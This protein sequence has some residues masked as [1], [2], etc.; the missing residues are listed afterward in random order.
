MVFAGMLMALISVIAAAGPPDDFQQAAKL[1]A[2]DAQSGDNFGRSVS[3]YGDTLVV[4]A[5]GED[6][7]GDSAGA[8]YVFT[9]SG[10]TW[11]QQAKL[12]ASDGQAG[13]SFG[14]SVSVYGDTVVVGAYGEDSGGS[15]AGAAY[16]FTRSGTTWSQQAKLTASDGQATTRFGVSVSVYGDT[17]VVGAVFE[18]SRGRRGRGVRVHAVAPGRRGAS[19]PSSRRATAALTT[20]SGRSVSLYGDTLVVGAGFEQS[21]YVFVRSGTTWSEQAKLTASDGGAGD[22]FGW[23]VSRVRRHGG[24]GR[25][26]RGQRGHDAGA[27]YVFTRSGTTWSQQAKLKASDGPGW[28]RVRA[29]GVRVRRHAGGGRSP[30]GQQG[31]QTRARRTTLPAPGPRGPSRPSS[32]RATPRLATGSGSR[33]PCTATRWW[34]ALTARTAGA[35]MRARRTSLRVFMNNNIEGLGRFHVFGRS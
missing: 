14:Y 30:R 28:R 15:S 16:V 22:R 27:A 19:R 12:T 33:C 7:R 5:T 6:S 1:T 18:D 10:T 9:R 24:G 25:L 21:A 13:D 2:S 11:T 35:R 32:R 26:P 17:L 8:A 4:G 20:T 3:V 23:S 29:L 34:W 31:R